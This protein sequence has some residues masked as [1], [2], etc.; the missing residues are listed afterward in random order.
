[1]GQRL[2]LLAR[3]RYPIDARCRAMAEGFLI[4][5]PSSAYQRSETDASFSGFRDAVA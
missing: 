1:M 2:Q 4:G 3:Q 5:W